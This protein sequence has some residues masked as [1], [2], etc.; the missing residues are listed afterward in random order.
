[1]NLA[2]VLTTVESYARDAKDRRTLRSGSVEFDANRF[3][4]MCSLIAGNTCII[5]L[6]MNARELVSMCERAA[7]SMLLLGAYR[8]ASLLQSESESS[9]IGA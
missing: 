7:V 2:R 4:R 1:M 3:G 5:L 6:R 8:L 9:V